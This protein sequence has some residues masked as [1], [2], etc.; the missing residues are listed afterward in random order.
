VAAKKDTT[1]VVVMAVSLAFW[2][3]VRSVF[4]EVASMV[5]LLDDGMVV[6]LVELTDEYLVFWM[7][8]WMVE[9]LV[10]WLDEFVVG[11]TE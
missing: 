6:W 2:L 11:V 1:L 3:V 10:P 9:L 4:C 7:A 8:V 5:A